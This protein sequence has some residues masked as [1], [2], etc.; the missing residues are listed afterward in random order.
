MLQPD[1]DIRHRLLIARLPAMP[2]ILIKLI[3]H[4]QAD[5]AG[6][7]ELAALIAKD[8]AMASKIFTVASSSAYHRHGSGAR[9]PGLEQ[10]LVALGTD[11]IKTLVI[12][13][14]VFQ[15]FNSFPHSGSTDLRAFWKSAL[16]T[17]VIARDLARA[18]EYPQVE[19][20][21]LA[22]LLHNVG[23][24]AL[25]ATAPREYAVNF[26]ARDDESLCAVEQRT[27]QI[28]HAE[29]GAWLIERWQLDSFLA[30]SVLYHHEPAARLAAAHPLIRM[31]RLAHLLCS[32]GD[33]LDAIG[34][35]AQLC[36]L[37]DA[38]L[39]RIGA[40]AARQVQQSADYLGIDL[41]GADDIV[42]PPAS[43][44]LAV[45]PVQQRLSEEVR[46]MMLVSEMAQT[47]GR[48]VGEGGEAGLL[49]AVTRSARVLFDFENVLVM[50]EN[51][52]GQALLGTA[53]GNQPGRLAQFMLAL[54]PA[55][56]G[57]VAQAARTRTPAY[58]CRDGHAAGDAGNRGGNGDS[59]GNGSHDGSSGAPL[60]L[61]E[62]QLF[63]ILGSEALV[64]LPLV[65][66]QRCLGVLIGGLPAWRL[67]SCRQRER[68]LQ[69][70]ATQAA[71]AL[72]TALSERGHARRQ[73][74]QVA[75]QY[76]EASRRVVHEVNNPLSIIKNYLSVLDSKLAR[77]EPVVG[78]LSIL[79]DE[80]DRVG[81][82][83]NGLADLQPGSASGAGQGKG[84][85]VAGVVD[86][87]LRLFRATGF[88]PASVQMVVRMQE[89]PGAI[90][91]DADLLKQVLVNLVKNAVEA[92]PDG[93]RIEIANR[94]LVNR[95]RRLYLELVVSD[96][97]PGLS[98][99]LLAN[100][101]A[102]VKS[103]KEGAHHGLGLSIVHGLVSRM[104]GLIACRSSNS[105]TT[106]EILLPAVPS[107]ASSSAGQPP[108][109]MDSV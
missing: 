32:H 56:G 58:V 103:T 16:T 21:Y 101:F 50:L 84:T 63:R 18:M 70:F 74:A 86:D 13:E 68:F 3:E 66:N 9:A 49:D 35:A 64:C 20:A 71:A 24:L 10:S 17:A 93:G 23:R 69:S 53:T 38:A 7:P 105:G 34:D 2:Q 26:M 8:P 87:V 33:E 85:D 99:E 95:E 108:R 43:A 37:D 109:L 47:F 45:D 15:T 36:G 27:L 55:Q 90:E 104:Q 4:L 81:Q 98:A 44:P 89:G 59:G 6:M 83:I 80:I 100:L 22:G 48:K 97:G 102:P 88:V 1:L 106:F 91:G 62:E 76:R 77:R 28:T 72:E 52:T 5:D 39:A 12:S 14:S 40:S 60:P 57:R 65:A 75:E 42:A 94:G 30:D 46:N 73:L 54:D 11:M 41:A 96:T 82:L 29:A 67:A 107:T 61:A 92:M 19:E 31:V 78:E 79:N 51:P 25:L